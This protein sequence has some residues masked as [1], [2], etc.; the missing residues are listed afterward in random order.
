MTPHRVLLLFDIDGTLLTTGGVARRAF[1]AAVRDVFGVEDDLGGV[2]FAGRTEPLIVGDILERRSLRFRDGEE[3]RFWDRLVA[4]MER[5]F[6]P[7][8]GR[9]LPGVPAVLDAVQAEPGFATGLLTGNLSRVARVK[10]ARFGLGSRFDFGAFGEEAP[11]RNAL[12]QLAARRARERFGLSPER[13]VVIGDT[14][15]DVECARAAGA[16]AVAVATGGQSADELA[17]HAPDLLLADLSDPEPLL[18]Y[19]RA[20]AER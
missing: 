10:L 2:E 9:L 14:H 13:I 7:P 19:A 6:V 16:H 1:A 20:V 18:A 11:D 5:Q 4:H 15:R 12:A 17:S 8:L 3:A